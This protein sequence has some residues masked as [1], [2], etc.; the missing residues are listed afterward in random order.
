MI[1][2]KIT[3]GLGNQ[4]FQYTYARTLR[5]RTKQEIL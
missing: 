1:V 3:D 4:L 2:V 5:N